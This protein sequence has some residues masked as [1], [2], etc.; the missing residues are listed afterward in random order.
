MKSLNI[1]PILFLPTAYPHSWLVCTDYTEK[2]AA[3][4]SHSKCRGYPR[5]GH[6]MVSGPF[7]TDT[8]YDTRP[9][10][11]NVCKNSKN[12]NSMYNGGGFRTVFLKIRHFLSDPGP[13]K[14]RKKWLKTRFFRA[15]GAF[16]AKI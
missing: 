6:Q 11:N 1:F 16:S 8:G 15:C 13:R 4:Y 14:S 5:N 3:Y 2:N 10:E 7:G 12:D 9:Q